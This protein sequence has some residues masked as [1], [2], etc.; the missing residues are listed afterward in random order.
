MSS[1]MLGRIRFTSCLCLPLVLCFMSLERIFLGLS[2]LICKVGALF[3][4]QK[5]L[6]KKQMR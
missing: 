5:I 6:I 3:R 1:S 2:G 4:P